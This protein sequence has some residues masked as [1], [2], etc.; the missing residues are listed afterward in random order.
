MAGPKRRLLFCSFCGVNEYGVDALITGTGTAI[1]PDCARAGLAALAGRATRRAGAGTATPTALVAELDRHVVA[2]DAAKRMLSVAVHNH[3]KRVGR[4]GQPG[5]EPGGV[6]LAKSNILLIGPSGTGKT[7]LAE[8]LARTLAVPFVVA[9]VTS[10]TQAGYAGEDIESVFR[11]LVIAADGDLA[12]AQRGIVFLDEVDKL[13][14]REA[15]AG[16]DVSGEGVQQGLLK[17]LEGTMVSL[18]GRQTDPTARAGEPRRFD[19]SEVLFMAGGAFVGLDDISGARTASDTF[20]FESAR[21]TTARTTD[22]TA[23]TEPGDLITFGLL[24]EFVGR[25]PVIV[26][27]DELGAAELR[28]VLTEPRDSLVA[29]YEELFRL[30]GHVLELTPDALTTIAERAHARATG[31]RGLRSVLETA[32]ADL[33]FHAPDLEPGRSLRVDAARITAALDGTGDPETG[34]LAGPAHAAGRGAPP[35]MSPAAEPGQEGG[36]TERRVGRTLRVA[37]GALVRRSA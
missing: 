33:M 27:L 32:L 17:S 24:P 8:T 21:R 29:Q 37:S 16:L 5:R 31:A 2:Q 3:F 1:C 12:A 26:R 30:D 10:L 35:Q 11:R 14:R 23:R 19:T 9:D 15:T 13:A 20:G 36:H 25:F 6:R 4:A 22:T 34:V 7:L 28:R 18:E